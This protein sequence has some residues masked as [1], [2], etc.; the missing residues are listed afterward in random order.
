M[1]IAQITDLHI[2]FVPN[3]PDEANRQRLDTALDALIDGPN[4]PDILIVSGDISDQGDDE[5]YARVAQILARAPFPVYPCLGNHD[6]RAAFSRAF[7]QV[8][9]RDGFVH[10]CIR[11]NGLR[12]IVLDTLEPGRHGGAFCNARAAWLRTQLNADR[13]TPTVIVMHHPPIDAGIAWMSGG[14]DEPWVQRFAGAIDGHRQIIA[15]WCG[16]LH[17]SVAS[18]WRGISVTI[19]PATAAQLALDL[20]PIDPELPDDRPMITADPPAYALHRWANNL[21]IT[22]FDTAEPH[23]TLAKF[24]SGLQPLVRHLAHERDGA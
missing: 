11:L 5:S 4:R 1:L 14:T 18:L 13:T 7:P 20:R 8:P 22:H 12:L 15:I 23:G 3:T 16:H 19:C 17:R 6:D 10:Y 2:G 9:V 24:D 21:L